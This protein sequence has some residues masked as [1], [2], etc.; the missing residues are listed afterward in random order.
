MQFDF[1]ELF[2]TTHLQDLP[3]PG[4]SQLSVFI[5]DWHRICNDQEDDIG[6][7]TYG[8]SAVSSASPTPDG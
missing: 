3:Y 4:D 5:E 7:S 6:V 8:A 2:N 1:K